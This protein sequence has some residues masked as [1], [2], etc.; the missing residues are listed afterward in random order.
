MLLGRR[1]REGGSDE[2]SCAKTSRVKG[3][4][5]RLL[6]VPRARAAFVG[7]A[8]LA[9][10]CAFSCSKCDREED[11]AQTMKA[12]EAPLPAPEGLL[13]DVYMVTPN[14]S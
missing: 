6:R 8:F 13:A 12:A 11:P 7:A 14:A 10:A 5:R 4:S 2:L 1:R 9:I 3:T